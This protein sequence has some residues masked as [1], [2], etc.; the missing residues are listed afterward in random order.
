MNKAFVIV[1]VLGLAVGAA[2]F[3]VSAQ[4]GGGGGG[5]G[6]GG[7]GGGGGRLSNPVEAAPF[8]GYGRAQNDYGPGSGTGMG[9]LGP[10]SGSGL[11]RCRPVRVRTCR[12]GEGDGRGP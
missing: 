10:G 11:G 7:G 12:G 4:G 1:G 2:A 6:G 9:Q 8:G 5:A 3:D